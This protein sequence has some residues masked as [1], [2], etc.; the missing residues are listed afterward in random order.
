MADLPADVADEA[1][2][3][4][5]LAREAVDENE[6]AA[7]RRERDE[8]LAEYG[9]TARIRAEDDTLVC[10]PEEWTDEAGTVH[11]GRIDDVDRGVERSLSGPGEG[12]DWDAIEAH[13]RSIAES[14]AA[15]YG[16]PHG[17]TA[18]ALAD[19]A[20]NHYAKPIEDLTAAELAEFREEYLPRNAWPS[21][22]Q[23]AALDESIRLLF[24]AADA[25]VPGEREE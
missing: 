13:N 15:E 8:V 22:E 10:Y 2:R 21:D 3:L 12:D 6:A 19:F 7:Y 1:A 25:P 9:Y 4:T 17:A 20:G 11:P 24:A 5:R 16:D 18:H 23:R 14:V